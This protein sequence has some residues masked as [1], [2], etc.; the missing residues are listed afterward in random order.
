[1]SS[2][3][4]TPGAVELQSASASLQLQLQL[5]L[6]ASVWCASSRSMANLNCNQPELRQRQRQRQRLTGCNTCSGLRTEAEFELGSLSLPAGN[7]AARSCCPNQSIK[8]L[9]QI[10]H[11]FI[12]N[13]AHS[14]GPQLGPTAAPRSTLIGNALSQWRFISC[15]ETRQIDNWSTCI[16][17]A[18]LMHALLDLSFNW[19]RRQLDNNTVLH[20]ASEYTALRSWITCHKNLSSST[21]IFDLIWDLSI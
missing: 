3:S 5:S 14:Y 21:T 1:M 7:W 10:C 12:S 6:S 20:S 4:P 16:S 18:Y 2:I 17:S 13:N 15:N 8:P 9:P 19:Q 11:G